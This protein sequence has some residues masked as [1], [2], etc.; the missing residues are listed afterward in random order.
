VFAVGDEKQSIFSFQGAEPAQFAQMQRHV[1]GAV[2]EGGA[3]LRG[4][5]VQIFVPLGADRARRG[6]Y[7]V[8]PREASP[9]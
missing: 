4:R 2:R 1:C 9:A 6:R 7:G 5:E 3:A 8:P